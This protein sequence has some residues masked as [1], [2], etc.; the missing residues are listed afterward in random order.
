VDKINAEG[1]YN[2]KNSG[3]KKRKNYKEKTMLILKVNISQSD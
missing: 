2:K 3:K 1:S